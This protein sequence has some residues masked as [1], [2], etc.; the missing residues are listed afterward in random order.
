MLQQ[1]LNAM[2]GSAAARGNLLTGGTM[3]DLNNYAQGMASTNYQQTYNNAFQNYLQ[4]YG[5]FQQ[6][7]QNQ[8]NRL[9][10]MAG[11]GETGTGQLMGTGA[12]LAN[13]MG[14]TMMTGAQQQA[15]AIQGGGQAQAAGYMNTANA[16]GS[17]GQGLNNAAFTYAYGPQIFGQQQQQQNPLW[18]GGLSPTQISSAYGAPGGVST[19]GSLPGAIPM[20]PMP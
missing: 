9:M 7:Q 19:L 20:Q 17:M 6:N 10:G 11:I 16:M 13:T 3:K 15:Q 1:G 18:Y 12:S 4:N 2:Q 14:N 8:Y 5:Q